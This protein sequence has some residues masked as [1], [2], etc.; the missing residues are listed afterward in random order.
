MLS[1]SPLP[2]P[3]L[4]LA[5]VDPFRDARG[6]FARWFCDRDLADVLGGRCIRQVNHSSSAQR[7][8]IRGLHL[9]RPPN[10]EMKLVRCIRGAVFDVAVDLR[11]GSPTYLRWHGEML[12]AA[13]MAMLCIPEGCA[14]GYQTLEDE[15]ELLY[16]VTRP[17]APSSERGLRFDDP[18][19]G[20][21]WPLPISAVSE[22]DARHP[23]L[24]LSAAGGK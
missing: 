12:S 6:S 5:Q 7:G 11:T 1:I 4:S 21:R 3:G 19:L 20:I 14:H 13:N 17:Y 10:E 18:A 24:D 9:Q 2:L 8:T 16:L 23:L 15:C 22:K